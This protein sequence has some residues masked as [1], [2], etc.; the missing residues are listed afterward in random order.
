MTLDPKIEQE[1]MSSVK[2][3]ETGSYITLSPDRTKAIMAAAEEETKKLEEMGRNPIVLTAPIV[4]IYFKKL[5][6]DYIKDLIVLSY[7]EIE[8]NVELQSVGIITA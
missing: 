3:T 6:E 7:N 8:S 1:I 2:Q 4:R 5:S